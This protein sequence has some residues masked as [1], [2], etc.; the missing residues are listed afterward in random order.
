MCKSKYFLR[1]V[2]LFLLTICVV[3]FLLSC[4]GK[5]EKGQGKTD[6]KN[7]VVDQVIDAGMACPELGV[8][9]VCHRTQ[10]VQAALLE[11][12]KE[13][14]C[15]KITV[16]Q[17]STVYTLTLDT[18]GVTNFKVGDFIGLT[19]LKY[20]YI[21]YNP[22]LSSLPA[23]LFQSATFLEWIDLSHNS[24]ITLPP[25]V[26]QGLT[27]LESVDL[28]YNQLN[29]LP[30]NMFQSITRLELLILSHNQLSSLPPGIFHGL[31]R[32][33]F[34]SIHSNLFSDEAIKQIKNEYGSIINRMLD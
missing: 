12:L 34:L 4:G 15:N 1:V 7:Q 20:L 23:C 30:L 14:D 13:S 24:L 3:G 29:S 18:K 28:S 32:I 9:S 33:D 10:Q 22:Q 8:M 21:R 16:D 25:G 27:F 19:K 6:K 31:Q 2:S 17:L 5:S 26:F 11:A